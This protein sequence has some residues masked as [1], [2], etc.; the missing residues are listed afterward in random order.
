MRAVTERAA[1]MNADL[2]EGVRVKYSDGWALI[3]PHSNDP[4]VDIWAEAAN[5]SGATARAEQWQRVVAEAIA[6]QS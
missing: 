5:D 3:L 4:Q 1:D 2:S 6:D